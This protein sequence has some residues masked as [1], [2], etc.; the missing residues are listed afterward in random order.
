MMNWKGCGEML[1][2]SIETL[3]GNVPEGTEKPTYGS[4]VWTDIRAKHFP[5]TS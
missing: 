2:D 1:H 5:S 3:S 4:S